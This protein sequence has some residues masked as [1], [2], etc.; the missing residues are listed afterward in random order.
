MSGPK[1]GVTMGLSMS[2][3]HC[4][5]AFPCNGVHE[6]HDAWSVVHT[7]GWRTLTGT[8]RVSGFSLLA[9]L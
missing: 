7:L 8:E 9:Y 4:W 6:T 1:G 3:G 5:L 2:E